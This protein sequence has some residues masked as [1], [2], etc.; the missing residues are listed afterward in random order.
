M[1]E[2]I[3]KWRTVLQDAARTE[4]SGGIAMSVPSDRAGRIAELVVAE[5]KCCPFFDF[6]LHF[7]GGVVEFEVRAP[8]Q[9]SAMLARV[10]GESGH[11]A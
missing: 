5:Q 10:F 3:C 2:R 9:A 1:A 11:H 4:I 8:A 7:R 6:R